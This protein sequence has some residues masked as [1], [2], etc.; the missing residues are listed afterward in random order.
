MFFK[1]IYLKMKNHEETILHM[2]VYVIE[3]YFMINLYI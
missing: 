1:I 2:M 3:I